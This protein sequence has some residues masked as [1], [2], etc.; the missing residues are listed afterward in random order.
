MISIGSIDPNK[1]ITAA[2]ITRQFYARMRAGQTPSRV[3]Y[4]NGFH[5]VLASAPDASYEEITRID[6]GAWEDADF[7]T[8]FN[9]LTYALQEF[10]SR[11]LGE[12]IADMSLV[13]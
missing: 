8:L 9:D 10:H 5:Y 6:G 7:A 1:S 13:A 2:A 12:A 3:F 4:K 11:R